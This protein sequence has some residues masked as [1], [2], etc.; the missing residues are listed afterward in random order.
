L[1]LWLL[2]V[3]FIL[4]FCD[5]VILWFVICDLCFLFVFLLLLYLQNNILM[6]LQMSHRWNC[7]SIFVPFIQVCEII[8]LVDKNTMKSSEIIQCESWKG[9]YYDCSTL[10][11]DS[12]ILSFWYAYNHIMSSKTKIIH[13]ILKSSAMMNSYI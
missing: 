7:C 11:M 1:V 4:R 6:T 10:S 2:L 5:F 12:G 9:L 13:R 3:L 8:I